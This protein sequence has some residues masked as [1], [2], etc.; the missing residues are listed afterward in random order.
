MKIFT[1]IE[2]IED[3][4]PWFINI[5]K[6]DYIIRNKDAERTQ[7]KFSSGETITT[8]LSPKEIMKKIDIAL[9]PFGNEEIIKKVTRAEL[10]DMGD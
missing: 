7:I 3:D 5:L 10:I 2:D 9:G 4:E 8:L 1:E 6:V